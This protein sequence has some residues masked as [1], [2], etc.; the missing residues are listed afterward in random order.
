MRS[1][2]TAGA[3]FG[4]L[5]FPFFSSGPCA[6]SVKVIDSLPVIPTY[7]PVPLTIVM[8]PSATPSKEQLEG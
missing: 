1:W 7:A 8:G 2:A 6:A 3:L 4:S 5:H